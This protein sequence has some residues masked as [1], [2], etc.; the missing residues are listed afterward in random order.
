MPSAVVCAGPSIEITDYVCDMGDLPVSFT[1]FI[2]NK[3]CSIS[4]FIYEFLIYVIYRPHT[5]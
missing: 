3:V 2:T 5:M 4:Y 1:S